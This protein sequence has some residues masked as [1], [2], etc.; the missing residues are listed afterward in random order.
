MSHPDPDYELWLDAQVE[1]MVRQERI[2][3]SVHCPACGFPMP[4]MLTDPEK[5]FNQG[6]YWWCC[7]EESC[8]KKWESHYGQLV[9][10]T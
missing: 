10:R 9:E 4:T 1:E 7:W 2:D 3:N 5:P 6:R 8:M